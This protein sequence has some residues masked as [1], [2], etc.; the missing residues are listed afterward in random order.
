MPDHLALVTETASPSDFYEKGT[1]TAKRSVAKLQSIWFPIHGT[2]VL[3]VPETFPFVGSLD[4][5]SVADTVG[6]VYHYI[7]VCMGCLFV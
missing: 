4:A 6:T 2:R 3:Y 5:V 7:E 1:W